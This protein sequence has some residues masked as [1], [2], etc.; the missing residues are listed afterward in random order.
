[1][2]DAEIEKAAASELKELNL[3]NEAVEQHDQAVVGESNPVENKKK[4]NKKKK[5]KKSN[6]KKIELLFPDGKYPEGEWMDYHQDFNLERTTDEESR[7][8][9][10]DLERAEHW[11]DVRKGAEIH[12]RVRRV[13]KDRIIPG[14]KLMDIADMIENTTRKYT[15]AEDL[16]AMENP[17]SQGIG[18]PTGL[19]LNH[20][21]AHYTPNAG[22]KTVLKYEDV[23]KVDYGVQI[24]GNIIDS[25]FTVSFDPQYDNLLAAVKDATY[26]GIKEAGI[27]VRLT[28]IGEAIQ[29]VMESYEVEIN[30]QTYQ[31]KPCR[32]L[33]GHSIGPY[34]IHGGKSV[35]IVKNGD[36]TKMEEGEH[37]AIETF[38]STGRG[39]VS[40]GGEVSHYAR[41]GEDN[42]VIP[43]LESAKNLLKTID[44]NFGTL[45]FC[46]RYLDRLGQEKYLFALNN[47]VRHGLVQDYPPLNDIPGSY[48]AQ[49]EHT[50][51]LHAHKKEVVS[52]GEDY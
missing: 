41:S 37:F 38:G 21:A 32:N 27:D 9:K 10:R 29:E 51:L 31:V 47:L 34:R 4:K 36:T 26:T 25:A 17:K 6:V 12:R 18:F 30:G 24:N 13:I 16:L 44:R 14:M 45:P 28:D 8:L 48:T 11:N 52:K 3:E 50:I 1:M 20:C 7:Y 22:D 43:T 15:G 2:S 23:M 35:P 42:Q 39:Y 5:K 40:A 49:F 46:R 19:S 33:C